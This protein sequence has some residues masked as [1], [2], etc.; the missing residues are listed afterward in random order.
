MRTALREQ[1]GLDA[2]HV[3][4]TSDE[5]DPGWWSDVDALGWARVDHKRMHTVERFGKVGKWCERSA[6]CRKI[7]N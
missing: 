1:K 5:E 4:M 3:V 2:T 7:E 6:N